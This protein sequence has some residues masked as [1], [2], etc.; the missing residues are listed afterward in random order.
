MLYCTQREKSQDYRLLLCTPRHGMFRKQ[1]NQRL[2]TSKQSTTKNTT[3]SNH[4]ENEV[5]TCNELQL[6]VCAEKWNT[7]RKYTVK[8]R[9]AQNSPIAPG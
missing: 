1:A 6:F 8:R 4:S 2:S 7:Y 5:V 9:N 3:H